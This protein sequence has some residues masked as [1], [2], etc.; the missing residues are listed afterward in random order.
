MAEKKVKVKKKKISKP[1]AKSKG[2]KEEVSEIF[3][4][5]KDGK[6]KVIK[7]SGIEEKQIIKKG[8]AKEENK[9]L[10]N[11]FLG[12]GIFLLAMVGTYMYLNSLGNFKYNGINFDIVEEGK[13]IFYHTMVP[14]KSAG[15]TV[16]YNI[17]LRVDPRK[18]DKVP[19]QGE[20]HPLEMMV[21]NNTESFSCNGDGGIAM[22]NLQ[23]IFGVFGTKIIRDENAE[24][25][26]F[27][28]YMYVKIQTGEKTMIEQ[29]GPA[30]YNL[31]VNN[32][33]ILEVT[34]K[35]ILEM[36]NEKLNR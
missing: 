21:L 13:V 10:R 32:C 3:E 9:I 8:Q 12:I 2:K 22:L 4:I 23:Q 19:F 27:G 36:L 5:E 11:L 30:C 20:F 34:E 35:F 25:D 16:N 17:F 33:E 31:N 29:V 26:E 24:C 14:M 18:T 28:R 6:E 7:T 1:S 15:K